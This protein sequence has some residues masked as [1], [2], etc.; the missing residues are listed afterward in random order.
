MDAW[1]MDVWKTLKKQIIAG[2][3]DVCFT[4]HLAAQAFANRFNEM[5]GKRTVIVEDDSDVGY[6]VGNPRP[7][8]Q[9]VA[10]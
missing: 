4:T 3:V 10:S 2:E 9:D 7:S 5:H 8:A 1:E 6:F